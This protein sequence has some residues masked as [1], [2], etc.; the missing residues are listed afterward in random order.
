MCEGRHAR[1]AGALVRL[2]PTEVITLVDV[3]DVGRMTAVTELAS[4]RETLLGLPQSAQ[5]ARV[6]TAD[7]KVPQSASKGVRLWTRLRVTLS[8]P[9]SRPRTPL[10]SSF[11]RR[12][13]LKGKARASRLSANRRSEI[14]KTAAQAHCQGC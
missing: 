10:P 14:A 2:A 5:I 13:G 9:L 7:V 3:V 11:G 4:P 6:E 8:R 1:L 12:G